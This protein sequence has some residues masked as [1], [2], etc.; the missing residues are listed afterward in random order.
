MSDSCRFTM[1]MVRKDYPVRPI[2]G[3]RS[4]ERP[5][6]GGFRPGRPRP[7]DTRGVTVTAPRPSRPRADAT[8]RAAAGTAAAP[9]SRAQPP[10]A[11]AHR[12]ADDA[13]ADG[14]RHRARGLAAAQ[15]RHLVPPADRA[16]AVG[17]L[18][19]GAPGRAVVL[20]DRALAADAVVHRDAGRPDGGLVRAARGRVA[21]RRAV[22]AL[23]RRGLRLLPPAGAG[24]CRRAWPPAWRSSARLRPSRRVL[25]WSAWCCSPSWSPRGCV[26]PRPC[27][28]PGT[29]SR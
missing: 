25:R 28:P 27:G 17:R 23:H 19:A 10:R 26:P 11:A 2:E 20:R 13:A 6:C 15:Q 5:R 29:W 14:R 18:V 16:R 24:R 12:R 8:S 1:N 22:P 3:P 9:G 4:R 7:A 21:V